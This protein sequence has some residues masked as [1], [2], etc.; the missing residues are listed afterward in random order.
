VLSL[1]LDAV[2]VALSPEA[3]ASARTQKKQFNKNKNLEI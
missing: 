3:R 1:A 2:K